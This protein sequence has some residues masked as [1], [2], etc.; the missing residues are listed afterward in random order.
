MSLSPQDMRFALLPTLVSRLHA[1]KQHD[2][3]AHRVRTAMRSNHQRYPSIWDI[4]SGCRVRN[5]K[6]Q[7]PDHVNPLSV[8]V[9][10]IVERVVARNSLL[11]YHVTS[12]MTVEMIE[13][14][15]TDVQKGRTPM[16]ARVTIA[17]VQPGKMDEGLQIVR[18]SVI[19][20]A[21]QQPGFK[22]LWELV[23]RSNNK[24]L[25]ISMWETEADLKAGETS[26]YY[27][28]QMAK[29]ASLLVGSFVREIYEVAIEA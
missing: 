19:P 14:I 13:N 18:D 15:V 17:Q 10:G 3:K 1:R 8:T 27:Q 9:L 5:G 28:E 25:A 12:G 26:G 22:G 24:V 2:Q 23:D 6:A 20:A 29:V 7:L 16:Y 11:Y 21:K 4:D